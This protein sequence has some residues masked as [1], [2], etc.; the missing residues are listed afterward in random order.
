[1]SINNWFLLSEFHPQKYVV[2]CNVKILLD[3]IIMLIKVLV[4]MSIHVE[5][6]F[7]K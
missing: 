2:G 7:K 5:L 3:Y 6:F 1:M 4:K